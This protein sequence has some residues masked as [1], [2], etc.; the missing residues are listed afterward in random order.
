[1]EALPSSRRSFLSL[2]SI[3]GYRKRKIM[4]S[5]FTPIG[6]ST[7]SR[8]RRLGNAALCWVSRKMRK[9]ALENAWQSLLRSDLLNLT[10]THP[11]P[12]NKYLYL[13]AIRN[14]I[15]IPQCTQPSNHYAVHLKIM[16][17]NCTS[18]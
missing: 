17:V 9:R 13:D 14:N 4:N 15:T 8:Q 2:I 5:T 18:I 1:M 3:S 10:F 16:Y 12:S 11:Q 7:V 6:E